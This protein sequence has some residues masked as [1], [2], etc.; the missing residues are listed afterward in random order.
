MHLV[1]R[2]HSTIEIYGGLTQETTLHFHPFAWMGLLEASLSLFGTLEFQV[3][4]S[5][6]MCKRRSQYRQQT[7]VLLRTPSVQPGNLA[8]I[9]ELLRL[10]MIFYSLTLVQGKDIGGTIGN[11]LEVDKR[12]WQSDQA[13]DMC[14]RVEF[15][16]NKPLRLGGYVSDSEG[17]KHWVTYKYERLPTLCFICGK[18]GHDI[19]HCKETTNWQGANKQYGDRMRAGWF[20]KGGQSTSRPNKGDDQAEADGVTDGVGNCVPSD[21][22]S[23]LG[24]DSL[25]GNAFFE[26]NQTLGNVPEASVAT[27]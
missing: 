23:V 19:K 11:F 4:V 2:L 15:Q 16:L 1:E 10:E 26:A 22:P 3:R 27:S 5:S 25:G 13:K 24:S 21:T 18:L 12:S 6:R 8:L 9:Y 20:S 14:L 7:S 17:G